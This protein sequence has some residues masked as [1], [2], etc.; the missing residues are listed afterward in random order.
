MKTAERTYWGVYSDSNSNSDFSGA[1][2]APK[3]DYD[4]SP[5][6]GSHA[7]PIIL[8]D[9]QI[10]ELK[11]EI[12]EIKNMLTTLIQERET[13]PAVHCITVRELTVG[14]AKTEIAKY[15]RDN[16]GIEIGYD[17]LIEG[18]GIE[19]RIVITACAELEKEGKIG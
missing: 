11:E 9:R 12:K 15:F 18:L 19:P 14:Q 3:P 6:R 16:D 10:A 17:D 13:L 2:G 8:Y 1:R 7:S 5:G 4:I